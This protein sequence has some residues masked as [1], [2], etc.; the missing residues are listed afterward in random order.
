MR[1]LTRHFDRLNARYHGAEGDSF[2][3]EELTPVAER[4]CPS[5]GRVLEVG[6]GYGRNLVALARINARLVVG[7]DP[8]EGD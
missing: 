8:A 4:F 3:I 5:G 2:A 1:F 6:C 7:S